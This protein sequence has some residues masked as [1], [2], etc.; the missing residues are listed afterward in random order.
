MLLDVSSSDER[1][2]AF[3][4]GSLAV[5]DDW[6][7]R[8]DPVQGVRLALAHAGLLPPPPPVIPDPPTPPAPRGVYLPNSAT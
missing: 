5:L 4:L 1:L 2:A 3:S 8:G 7:R 6:R